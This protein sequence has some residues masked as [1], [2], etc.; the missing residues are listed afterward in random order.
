MIRSWVVVNFEYETS[1]HDVKTFVSMLAEN[2][3]KLG[4]TC[5]RFLFTVLTMC[6][7]QVFVREVY[8]SCGDV[9]ILYS[10]QMI[11]LSG[12][13]KSGMEIFRIRTQ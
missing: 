8:L 1:R 10:P 3:V 11:N 2:L 7:P 9:F 6:G 4:M 13:Q 5:S 12:Y